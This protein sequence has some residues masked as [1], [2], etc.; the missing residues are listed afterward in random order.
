M[1]ISIPGIDIEK[2]IK[3]SG[4]E[5]LLTELFGDVYKIIDEKS[6]LIET[7]LG[8]K[9]LKNYT[10]QVH[11]LKTT[12]RMIG[13]IDLGEDFFS[14]EMLGK[15]NNLEQAEKLTP[16][17]LNAFRSLKPYLEPF[18]TKKVVPVNAFDK[19]AVSAILKE[20]IEA[21][22]DFDLGTAEEATKKLCSYSCR[23]D[24]SGKLEALE[25]HVSNLDYDEA[26]EL[27][28][29]ILESL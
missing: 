15:E 25:N 16:D 14:L 13:A 7:F 22:D 27:A 26:K 2:G 29:Q 3:N 6:D 1:N 4:S 17:I 9:D 18:A 24:L 21:I 23:D 5:E 11:A 8:A 12:C 28:S 10:T 19:D 20:L